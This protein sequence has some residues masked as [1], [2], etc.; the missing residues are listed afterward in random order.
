MRTTNDC[1]NP[2]FIGVSLSPVATNNQENYVVEDNVIGCGQSLANIYS[3]IG[4][5]NGTVTITAS[6]APFSAG[7]AG[8]RIRLAAAGGTPGP[9]NF[10]TRYADTTIASYVSPTQ[11]KI[12]AP[13]WVSTKRY[14]PGDVVTGF[15]GTIYVSGSFNTSTDPMEANPD[16]G[17]WVAMCD[18]QPSGQRA[19]LSRALR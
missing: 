4:S 15:N 2:N 17:F 16:A 6:D 19:D 18:K 13:T 14:K 5:T 9:G 7:D 1:N 10:V 12:S 11:V 8:K 3:R